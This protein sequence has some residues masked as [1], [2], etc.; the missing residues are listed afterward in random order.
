M[1]RLTFPRA[2][3]KE[4]HDIQRQWAE[5]H[6]RDLG[7][8]KVSLSLP[9][10]LQWASHHRPMSISTLNS[11]NTGAAMTI[12]SPITTMHSPTTKNGATWSKDTDK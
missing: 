9:K 6:Q 5:H 2:L 12:Q 4:R 10:K 1:D 3:Q 11:N 8:L 7:E